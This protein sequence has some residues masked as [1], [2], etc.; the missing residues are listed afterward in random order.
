MGYVNHWNN[1]MS[2]QKI[3]IRAPL[4]TFLRSYPLFAGI[5]DDV[6]DSFG[7]YAVV[8]FERKGTILFAPDAPNDKVYIVRSG[9]VKLFRE[10]LSGEE[11]IVDVLT[12]GN[13]F[14]EIGLAG[15]E[16]MPYG[17]EVAEDAEIVSI[18]RFLVADE[19][20]RNSVFGLAVLQNLTRQKMQRDL[21]IEHRTVQ[22]APQRIGCFLLKLCRENHTGS[23]T[24]HLPYDKSVM[25][26]RLGMQPETFSRALAR[27]REEVDLTIQGATVQIP[28]IGRLAEFSCAACSSKFPC[29]D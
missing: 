15:T 29:S 8:K 5:K 25:A 27:L 20:M 16:P 17:A 14:G 3:Q 18:P 9:W 11:A 19:V 21:E 13:F 4:Q 22:S 12:S 1:M 10:T 24:L 7:S 26:A 2:A 23:V 6:V 28:D